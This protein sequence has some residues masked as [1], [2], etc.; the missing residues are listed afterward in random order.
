MTW[1][2]RCKLIA[3]HKAAFRR[4]FNNCVQKF[5]KCILCNQHAPLGTAKDFFNHV[6]FQQGVSPHIHTC[7]LLW[8]ENAPNM[9][10]KN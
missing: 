10:N 3:S 9:E 2:E 4:Y 5:I 8:V 1:A 7:S 6:E